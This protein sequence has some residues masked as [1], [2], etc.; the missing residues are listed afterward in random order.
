MEEHIMER[1]QAR[2]QAWDLLTGIYQEMSRF[3][4][5]EAR[6]LLPLL[7]AAR[8]HL[9]SGGEKPWPLQHPDAVAYDDEAWNELHRIVE[10]LGLRS[11]DPLIRECEDY[12][13][14]EFTRSKEGTWWNTGT[15]RAAHTAAAYAAEKLYAHLGV[16]GPPVGM[17][18]PPGT[19][20]EGYP[21]DDEQPRFA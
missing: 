1:Y 11:W 5:P 19:L 6:E 10:P 7:P 20:P 13:G 17:D 2:R 21:E 14:R 9:L 16:E 3:H 12:V 4:T 8:E 18:P 15:Y